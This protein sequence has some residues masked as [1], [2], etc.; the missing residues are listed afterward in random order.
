M[1]MKQAE[2]RAARTPTGMAQ[3]AVPMM[4]IQWVGRFVVVSMVS[5]RCGE[6]LMWRCRVWLAQVS[7]STSFP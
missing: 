6:V 7:L 1:K 2:Q 5:R 4:R 3:D